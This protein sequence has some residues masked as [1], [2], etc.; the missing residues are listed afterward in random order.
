MSKSMRDANFGK[1]TTY[2]LAGITWTESYNCY[3]AKVGGWLPLGFSWTSDKG[4][5]VNVNGATL[6]ARGTDPADAARIAVAG[7]KNLMTKAIEEMS[8]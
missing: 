8:Q 7:A 6:K 3:T 1:R 4:W 5:V 2:V